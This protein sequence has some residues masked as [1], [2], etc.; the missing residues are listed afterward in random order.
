MH[1]S[2]FCFEHTANAVTLRW[3]EA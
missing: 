3:S 1:E 2:V